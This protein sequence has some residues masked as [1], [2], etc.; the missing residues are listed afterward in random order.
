[1]KYADGT[2][3][4]S[5]W[6]SNEGVVNRY[7]TKICGDG[8]YEIVLN[9]KHYSHCPNLNP[10][11]SDMNNWGNEMTPATQDQVNHIDACIKAENYVDPPENKM[12][13]FP[14]EFSVDVDENVDKVLQCLE[15][16]GAK[17][18]S[19]HKPTQWKPKGIWENI[20]CISNELSFNCEVKDLSLIHI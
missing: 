7:I 8:C 5:Q 20:N 1:M 16:R 14:Q 3:W 15:D 6:T 2:V 11:N 13:E 10:N 4:C 9:D 17:W 19:G 18:V 12:K